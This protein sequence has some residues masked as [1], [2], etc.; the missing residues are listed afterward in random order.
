MARAIHDEAVA[1]K[2]RLAHAC[3]FACPT[4]R[5]DVPILIDFRAGTAERERR[6]RIPRTEFATTYVEIF[7]NFHRM[8]LDDTFEIMENRDEIF[9][10]TDGMSINFGYLG[11]LRIDDEKKGNENWKILIDLF[12]V[13]LEIYFV[14]ELESNNQ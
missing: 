8:I 10:N 2:R 4:F 11:N 7:E 12:V 1:T 13:W 14:V 5:D 9:R 6:T 3:E